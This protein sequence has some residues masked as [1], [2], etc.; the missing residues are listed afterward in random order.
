MRIFTVGHSNHDERTFLDLLDQH[1]IEVLADV[2]SQPYSRYVSHFNHDQIKQALTSAGLQYVFLGKELGGRPGGD[3]FYDDDGYVLYEQVAQSPKF[4]SGVERVKKGIGKY[5]VAMMCSEENP[6]E[7]HRHLLVSRVLFERG[8]EIAHI[9]GDGR[10]ESHDQVMS[11]LLGHDAGQ[12]L[13]F[14][15]LKRPMWKSSR[16]VLPRKRPA[17]SLTTESKGHHA[18]KRL[19][20]Q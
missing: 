6:T 1:K 13:L 10:L 20:N 15:E 5:R 2:R 11:Q 4:L 12:G 19:A 8:V 9:R 18:V 14:E 3:D 7:C 16:S 17:D